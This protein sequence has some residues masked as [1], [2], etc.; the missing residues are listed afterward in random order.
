[1]TGDAG[2]TA[3]G[4]EAE[5]VDAAPRALPARGTCFGFQLRSEL[6]WA[7]LRSGAGDPLEVTEG[8]PPPRAPG[9][10]VQE[11]LP[12]W[13]PTHVKLYRD[14]AAFHLWIEDGGWFA[15]DPGRRRLRVP[16]RADEVRREERALGLPML[17][18][19]LA[20]GDVPLHAAAVDVDGR[21]LLLSGPRRFGKTTLAAAFAAAGYRVLSE[22]LVCIRPG[23]PPAVVPG[24]A[25]L[26][27]R[28]DMADEIRIPGARELGRDDDRVHLSLEKGRGSCDPVPLEGI[29]FLDE[30]DTEPTLDAVDAV[31]AVRSLWSVSFNL[32]TEAD[33]ERCFRAVGDLASAAPTWRLRRRLRVA[34]LRP[35]VEYLVDAVAAGG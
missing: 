20:R 25:M 3:E 33:R 32:P 5:P 35:T 7:Y 28:H 6:D 13:S 18:C 9:D 16:A 15:V 11:W 24:P 34:D 17:L 8:D 23:P 22:D 21:A 27:V 30:D 19:F 12:P 14:G 2:E 4:A 29:A 26:R 1:M 31:Q 10:L